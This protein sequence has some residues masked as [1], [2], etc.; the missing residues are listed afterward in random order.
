LTTQYKA[1]G[2]PGRKGSTQRDSSKILSAW[3]AGLTLRRALAGPEEKRLRKPQTER[4]LQ[5]KRILQEGLSSF[6]GQKK[7]PRRGS[8]GEGKGGKPSIPKNEVPRLAS[9]EKRKE[10]N[11]KEKADK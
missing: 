2:R 8:R 5:G 6:R 11:G 1:T 7:W 10:G 4:S 3:K 9:E